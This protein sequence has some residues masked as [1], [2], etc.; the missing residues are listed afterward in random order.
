MTSEAARA[1]EIEI[2]NQ[3]RFIQQ[4]AWC[5]KRPRETVQQAIDAATAKLRA[6]VEAVLGDVENFMMSDPYDHPLVKE[7]VE[8]LRKIINRG[9]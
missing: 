9:N 6:E 2:I 7:I 8:P 3:V 4:G 5:G 1:A